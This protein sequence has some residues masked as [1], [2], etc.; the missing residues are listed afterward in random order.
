MPPYLFVM[1][2]RGPV[3]EKLAAWERRGTRIVNRPAGIRNTDRERTIAL[4]RE[5][6]VPYPPSVL[7]ET[8]SAGGLSGPLLGEARRR[9][10]HRGGRRLLLRRRGRPRRD[11][12]PT[13]AAR[14]RAR[15]RPGPRPRRP[16][17]VL[18]RGGLERTAPADPPGSSGSTTA[19]RRSRTTPSTRRRSAARRRARGLG[20]RPRGLR[21]RRDRLGGRQALRHRPERLAELRPLPPR[22]R[23]P[24]RGAARRAVF[25]RRE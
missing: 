25:A 15:R 3:V 2:E 13:F 8:R 12:R 1:C 4:F 6:G 17:Q 24:H 23:R 18:R 5:H 20:A 22:C 10:R 11:R 21:R 7:V 16:D 9:P 19:T 14:H